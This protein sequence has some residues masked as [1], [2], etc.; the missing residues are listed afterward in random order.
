MYLI[1]LTYF[2]SFNKHRRNMHLSLNKETNR[3]AFRRSHE[4]M[5]T[6]FQCNSADVWSK[7]LPWRRCTLPATTV[8][9]SPLFPYRRGRRSL[10]A[11]PFGIFF[12]LEEASMGG[13]RS[14]S[15]WPAKWNKPRT[16]IDLTFVYSWLRKNNEPFQWPNLDGL[17]SWKSID[18]ECLPTAP[19]WINPTSVAYSSSK[20]R[21]SC[22]LLILRS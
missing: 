5:M 4:I 12:L 8:D 18:A 10:C 3:M 13:T 9:E 14:T 6:R 1:G 22:R 11:V 16:L 20:E 19:C 7:C 2:T 21:T 17:T 15:L